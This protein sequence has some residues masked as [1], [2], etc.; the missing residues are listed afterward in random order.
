MLSLNIRLKIKI[1]SIKVILDLV[2]FNCL[3]WNSYISK[4]NVVV[5]FKIFIMIVFK[6]MRIEWKVIIKMIYVENKIRVKLYGV[7]L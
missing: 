2:R 3:F 6:G 1:G 5:K 7:F 4:L